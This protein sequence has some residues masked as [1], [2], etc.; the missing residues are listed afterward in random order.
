MSRRQYSLA[1]LFLMGCLVSLGAILTRQ[2][3]PDIQL[4]DYSAYSCQTGTQ[5]ESSLKLHLAIPIFIK[6]IAETLCQSESIRQEYNSV[7]VSWKPRDAITAADII[8]SQFSL[9]MGRKHTFTGLVPTF[10]TSYKPLEPKVNFT[11]YP[12]YWF[13]R[14]PFAQ[15]SYSQLVGKRI[16]II[17]DKVSHTHYLLP[18]TAL[19]EANVHL[20]QV[21]LHYYDNA[22]KLYDAF[23]NEQIDLISSGAWFE[24]ELAGHVYKSLITADANIGDIFVSNQL[25]KLQQ[26]EIYRAIQPFIQFINQLT[27]NRQLQPATQNSDI[28]RC[29]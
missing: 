26:C 19:A 27:Q 9:L 4:S 12:V 17:N 16:G 15:N 5:V 7:I 8:D 13:S 10:E 23:K 3:V 18:L 11:E 22:Y 28:G 21:E 29:Q 2:S 14:A 25:S 20:D 24:H 1:L 6:T